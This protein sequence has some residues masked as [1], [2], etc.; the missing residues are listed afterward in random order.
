MIFITQSRITAER[1]QWAEGGYSMLHL[2]R[3][4]RPA[5]MTFCVS[6]TL[7]SGCWHDPFRTSVENDTD[8]AIDVTIHFEDRSLP[9]GHGN[10]EPGN[11][12][13]LTQ[14][15]EDISYIEYQIGER[16]CRMDEKAISKRARTG[17]RGM[18]II[19]LSECPRPNA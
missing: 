16:R 15:V 10:I 7:L 4:L 13:S 2:G 5:R 19:A 8:Q 12:V 9:P 14:R 18:T 17:D 1:P 3:M 11:G 6:L